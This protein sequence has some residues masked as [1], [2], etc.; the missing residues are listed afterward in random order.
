MLQP[1]RQMDA[2]FSPGAPDAIAPLRAALQ[3]RYEFE[4]E[5]GQGA[6][7]TVYLARDLKHERKVAIKVLNADPASDTG[8]L[9]F[10]REIRM[11]ARL[12]HPNILPLHDSGHVEAFLYYVMPYV[13]GDTLRDFLNRARQLPIRE[14][15]IIARDVADALAYAHGEGIIHRDVKPENIL[16]STG[17]PIVADFGIARVIDLVAARQLT[18]TG[19]GSPGTPAYMS[20][21]QLLGE[22]QIDGRSDTY[23]LGCVFYEMLAG[24]PPFAGKEGFVKRFTEPPPDVRDVRRDVPESLNAIVMRTLAREP[25]DR[26]QSAR[27]LVDALTSL[28]SDGYPAL[29]EG[30]RTPVA[31]TPAEAASQAAE[32]HPLNLTET[33]DSAVRVSL[34]QNALRTGEAGKRIPLPA[35]VVSLFVVVLALLASRAGTLRSRFANHPLDSARVVVLP[36]S[37]ADTAFGISVAERFYDALQGWSDLSVVA[38]TR[39]AETLLQRGRLP[40]TEDDALAIA[41]S[42][43]AGK[44]VWGRV[45]G[46]G[47]SARIG[48][49]MFD[50]ATKTS[51]SEL[52]TNDPGP[53]AKAYPG[54]LLRLLKPQG[55]P[56]AADGGDGLTR[57]YAAWSAYGRAHEALQEGNLDQAERGFLAALNADP[58]YA[59]AHLW[60][61]QIREWRTPA[62]LT[63][64][65]DHALRAS[66]SNDLRSRDKAL[67]AALVAIGSGDYPAACRAYRAL[68]QTD[69]TDFAG[70]FGLGDCQSL[71]SLVIPS[72]ASPSGW[73]FR[74]SNLAAANAYQHAVRL[75]PGTHAIFNFAKLESLLPTAATRVRFGKSAPPKRIDFI[76]SPSLMGANDTLAFVPY[77]AA[78]FSQRPPTATATLSAA[79]AKNA[80]QLLDYT[81]QWTTTSRSDP[82]AFEALADVLDVRG[83]IGDETDPTESALSALTKAR[84]LARDSTQI[85]RL[86][87][88][89]AWIRFKR[90]EFAEAKH[91]ADAVLLGS[92]G[93]TQAE[94]NALVGLA[95][96][97]GRARLMA[98][99]SDLSDAAIP[100]SLSDV[101]APVR[102]AAADFFANS[103]LGA[104]SAAASSRIALNRAIDQNVAPAATASTSR[105][106]IARP[107]SLL[108][109]CTN[110]RSILEVAAP[111][112]RLTRLE[113]A[114]ALGRK[115]EFA[116]LSDS[117]AARIVNRRPGDLS[118]DFVYLQSWLRVASG[119]TA[120]AIAQLDRSLGAL[121][122]VNGSALREPGSA[123]AIVRAMVLRADLAAKTG[124]GTTAKRWAGAV[125][126]LWADAD[127]GLRAE[128]ARMRTLAATP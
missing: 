36:L 53:D 31:P 90:G 39:V 105:A 120:G 65:R 28:D 75:A 71:D 15:C 46:R 68:T 77:P 113:K 44:L 86:A 19:T 17:H 94:A 72:I 76:A 123:A 16:M 92:H 102:V 104:C 47:S 37:A 32:H 13:S 55:W 5:L 111:G 84:S 125:L 122:G 57:S 64:W 98:H 40:Q 127:Q 80:S 43:G 69:S 91:L 100:S 2:P 70:W 42:L 59:V 78:S 62:S 81:I 45:S 21:E 10:I 101:S 30:R 18:R 67:A 4:R 51:T 38:D 3:G 97:T 103:A 73:A 29:V 118:P 9:R 58:Q 88:K 112:D 107:L 74:T 1:P 48:V 24:K 50:V 14:S 82:A 126:I 85:L 89:E 95:A 83:Q 27:D 63:A 20:P 34:S 66:A 26:F 12:Q 56:Q 41:R 6:F 115:A 87:T 52:V 60:L 109:P 54:L 61:A 99:L 8:E 128:V 11:L 114:Y 23:S 124:A 22:R 121:P 108:V 106:L 110:G 49:H 116:A 117:I 25:R 33:I 7:A 35:L 96:L 93:E 79:I 119:D